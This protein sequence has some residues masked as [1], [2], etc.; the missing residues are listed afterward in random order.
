MN[1]LT[2]FIVSSKIDRGTST[3]VGR[4]RTVVHA[5]GRSKLPSQPHSWL[6]ALTK[7][8]MDQGQLMGA[9]GGEAFCATC[10]GDVTGKQVS[11]RPFNNRQFA[12]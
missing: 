3:A 4:L 10:G 12:C 9:K 6:R 8:E 7:G 1:K 11:A 5:R 2:L